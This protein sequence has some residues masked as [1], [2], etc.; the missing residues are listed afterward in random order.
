MIK[1]KIDKSYVQYLNGKRKGV[2]RFLFFKFYPM[3]EPRT[4]IFVARK[5]EREGLNTPEW[6]AVA[7][8]LATI[9]LT[10]TL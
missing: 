1:A 7:S 10:V 9:G 4:T 5:P 6:L 8:S 2:E 3:I